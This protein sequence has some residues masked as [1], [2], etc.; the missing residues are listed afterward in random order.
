MS[1]GTTTTETESKPLPEQYEQIKK[2]WEESGRLYDTPLQDFPGSQVGQRDDA[3]IRAG[4]MTEGLAGQEFKQSGY[5]FMNQTLQGDFMGGPGENPTLDAKWSAMSDRI[6]ESYNRIVAPGTAS[7]FAGAGRSGSMA[8]MK[9]EGQDQRNLS[10]GLG[11]TQAD[12][13]YGDYNNRMRDRMQALGLMPAVSS[14]G[15]Q[16][17]SEN[18]KQG[19]IEE[20][21][22]QRLLNDQVRR[23]NFA[24]LEPEQRLDR[25][26]Q[27]VNQN[28]GWGVNTSTAPDNS[29]QAIG[30]GVLG[31]ATTL[32]G[33]ALGGPLGGALASTVTGAAGGGG[34][35]YTSQYSTG[36]LYR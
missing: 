24:Q 4:E 15:Y 10:E 14:V 9:S 33:T 23:F 5:D 8:N 25:F 20:N 2:F 34:D 32:A 35:Q 16:D 36:G 3:S 19:V 26:G 17:I 12:I 31:A 22:T 21:Y 30:L 29:G 28:N 6:G 13:Y 27:R 18:R 11:R 7:R 1:S